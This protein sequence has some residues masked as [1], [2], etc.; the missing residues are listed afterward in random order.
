MQQRRGVVDMD[1]HTNANLLGRRADD[2]S[3]FCAMSLI[4]FIYGMDVEEAD[5]FIC[6]DHEHYHQDNH[7]RAVAGNYKGHY[8]QVTYDG[9]YS[10]RVD[11]VTV[12]WDI[13]ENELNRIMATL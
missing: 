1:C 7:I 6:R 3:F 4:Q 10:V 8:V 12:G 11:G 2:L 5:D 13:D 9:Q